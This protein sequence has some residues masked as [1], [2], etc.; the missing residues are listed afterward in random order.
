MDSKQARYLWASRSIPVSLPPVQ[1]RCRRHK[2]PGSQS[3]R[4]S[5]SSS[6]LSSSLHLFL[7]LDDFLRIFKTLFTLFIW[8]HSCREGT[9]SPRLLCLSSS[10]SPGRR[11]SKK[12]AGHWEARKRLC[13]Y[14]CVCLC[15]KLLSTQRESFGWQQ[16]GGRSEKDFFCLCPSTALADNDSR[17]FFSLTTWESS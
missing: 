3:S 15:Q 16:E 5:P 12:Q 14:A 6:T 11:D 8:S 17:H 13:V 7:L 1:Q 4:L 9:G 2:S 10:S